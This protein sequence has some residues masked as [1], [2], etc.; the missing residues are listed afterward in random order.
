MQHLQ[1]KEIIVG[2]G[3]EMN[4]KQQ[5]QNHNSSNEGNNKEEEGDDHNSDIE[6][7]ERRWAAIDS[8]CWFVP[9]SGNMT[10]DRP[11]GV[12]QSAG[13]NLNSASSKDVWELKISNIHCILEC[14]TSR[15]GASQKLESTGKISN[16]Q[17][18]EAHGSDQD[19]TSTVH[20]QPITQMYMSRPPCAN[21]EV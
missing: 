10:Q 15:E 18:N 4:R 14:G 7:T 20:Q 17:N 13:G 1:Y 19:Q 16:G 6:H 3:Y 5:T 11:E 2:M 8:A 21:K 9:R 12:F